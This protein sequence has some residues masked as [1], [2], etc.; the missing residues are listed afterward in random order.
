MWWL[1][2]W[3]CDGAWL[4]AS[5][6]LKRRSRPLRKF[7]SYND[8]KPGHDALEWPGEVDKE[9]PV[10]GTGIPLESVRK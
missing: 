6:E 8:H 7:H 9:C 10:V 5:L 2:L 3:R 1:L 4:Y